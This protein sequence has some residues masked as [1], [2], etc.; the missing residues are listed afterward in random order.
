MGK[1]WKKMFE[2]GLKQNK[3]MEQILFMCNPLF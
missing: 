3:R 2:P 1:E